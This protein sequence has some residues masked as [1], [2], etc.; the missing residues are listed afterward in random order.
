MTK[1]LEYKLVSCLLDQLYS[2]ENAAETEINEDFSIRLM[3]QVGAELQSLSVSDLHV[4]LEQVTE[5]AAR[6]IDDNRKAF[7]S[8]F[9]D[10]FGLT[11]LAT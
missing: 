5:L 7:L 8:E 9:G 2:L 10:N 1:N 11:D 4:L 6:E 3:E